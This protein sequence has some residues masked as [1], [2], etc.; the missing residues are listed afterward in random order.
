MSLDD[1]KDIEWCV[2]DTDNL[3]EEKTCKQN[4]AEITMDHP[5]L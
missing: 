3:H 1:E 4:T 5:G 2:D